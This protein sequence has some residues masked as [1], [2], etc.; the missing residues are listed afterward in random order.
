MGLNQKVNE[1][2]NTPVSDITIHTGENSDRKEPIVETFYSG[3]PSPYARQ[4]I[5]PVPISDYKHGFICSY[6]E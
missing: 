5:V 1:S 4:S 6:K 2:N 3:S